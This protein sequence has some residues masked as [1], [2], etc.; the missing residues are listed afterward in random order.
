MKKLHGLAFLMILVLLVTTGFQVYWLKDNYRREEKTVETRTRA[1]FRETVREMQDS[2]W[3]ARISKALADTSSRRILH[4]SS[5]NAGKSRPTLRDRPRTGRIINLLTQQLTIDSSHKPG[6]KGIFISVKGNKPAAD[7]LQKLRRQLDSLNPGEI[8]EMVVVNATNRGAR[9][10]F[11]DSPGVMATRTFPASLD[12]DQQIRRDSTNEGIAQL[13]TIYFN[14]EQGNRVVI[15]MDS[16]F[17]DSLPVAAVSQRFATTLRQEKLDVPF[18]VQRS[19]NGKARMEEDLVTDHFGNNAEFQLQLG[20]TFPFLLRRISLPILFSL[21]LVGL[22]L[23]SFILL[24]RSLLRQH[25][26]AI[27]KNDLMSNIT[28]EL[29]TPIATVGVAIEAL[30]NFNAIQDPQKTREY[31]DISQMELQ[32]LGLLVDKVLKLSMFENN[33]MEIK[34]EILDLEALVNEV[35]DSLRLQLEKYQARVTVSREGDV[36]IEG[37]RLHLQSVVFNLL[38]NALKYSKGN[39]AIDVKLK[40]LGDSVSIQFADNGIGI[41]AQYREKVFEKFFR[42][43]AGDTHNAKGHG[44]G[45]SYV[46]QVLDQHRGSISLDSQEGIGSIFTII[47]PKHSV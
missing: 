16:L 42:V 6:R 18:T 20:N 47:L 23:F 40:D 36:N 7:S 15:R 21:F 26:L 33:K 39:L 4:G 1:L 41:P 5:R 30:K 24:Y 2:I 31:L 32:R 45:L 29:K 44:L 46:A 28:H 3:Q 43:P 13:N 12:V 37:D 10:R 38:D 35:K 11:S 25:R 22:T 14:D 34:K 19:I 9:V 8:N 17:L 27:F